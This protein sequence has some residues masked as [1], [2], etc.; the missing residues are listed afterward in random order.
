MF[1]NK[2]IKLLL[3]FRGKIPEKLRRRL[4]V[5][6]FATPVKSI[7]AYNEGNNGVMV[8]QPQGEFEYLAYQADNKLTISVK[9][10]LPDAPQSVKKSLFIQVKSCL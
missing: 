6:D 10:I 5:S 3:V 2:V 4:D 7:D 1:S 8:I 9:P